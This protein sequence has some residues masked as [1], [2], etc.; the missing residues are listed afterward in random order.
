MPYNRTPTGPFRHDEAEAALA[1]W[2]DLQAQL[3]DAVED[4]RA[5]LLSGQA[6]PNNLS[7]LAA[8]WSHAR[9]TLEVT[10]LAVE[11][12]WLQLQQAES[13]VADG[14]PRLAAVIARAVSDVYS[15][16]ALTKLTTDPDSV[17]WGPFGA[18]ELC[19]LQQEPEQNED[20][21]LSGELT[22][23]YFRAPDTDPL[24]TDGLSRVFSERGYNVEIIARGSTHTADEHTDVVLFRVHRAF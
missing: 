3:E 23:T 5:H 12:C 9:D 11:G 16:R 6:R 13:D 14:P 18:P 2:Q 22:L 19:L 7:T 15:G 17:Y 20:G 8:E 1:A 21:V 24:D 10:A 4:L